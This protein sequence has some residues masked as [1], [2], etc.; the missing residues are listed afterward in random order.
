MLRVLLPLPE[1]TARL[2]SA[3]ATAQ[4]YEVKNIGHKY[5]PYKFI[6]RLKIFQTAFANP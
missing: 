4:F 6:G 1:Q 2:A 5:L 3:A